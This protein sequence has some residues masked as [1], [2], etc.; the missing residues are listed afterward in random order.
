MVTWHSYRVIHDD[1]IRKIKNLNNVR[2]DPSERY[3][4]KRQHQRLPNGKQMN[5]LKLKLRGEFDSSCG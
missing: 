3:R 2:Y 4:D 5:I 1:I